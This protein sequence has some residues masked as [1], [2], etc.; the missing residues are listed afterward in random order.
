MPGANDSCSVVAGVQSR[1]VS[2]IGGDGRSLPP[3][4]CAVMSVQPPSTMPCSARSTCFCLTDF[5]CHSPH[6]VCSGN[7]TASQCVCGRGWGGEDC[8]VALLQLSTARGSPVVSCEVGIVDAA[9]ACCVGAVDV[10]SGLCCPR[11]S[12]VDR[13]GHC[14]SEGVLDPCGV[15]NGTGVAVDVQGVCCQTPLPPSGVCCTTG[16]L[17]S[18]GVCNGENSCRCVY[19]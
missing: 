7:A 19:A 2:C 1:T 18:C 11:N 14:C 6:K 12:S 10:T 16:V 4:H 13:E 9:G 3:D 8:D 15:C 17:D 5:D